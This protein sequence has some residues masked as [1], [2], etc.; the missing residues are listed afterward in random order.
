M[1]Y[2]K[3]LEVAFNIVSEAE[4]IKELILNEINEKKQKVIQEKVNVLPLKHNVVCFS[5]IYIRDDECK[6]TMCNFFTCCIYSLWKSLWKRIIVRKLNVNSVMIFY[7]YLVVVTQIFNN[8][9]K[10]C[11]FEM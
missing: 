6:D 10:K 9:K 3:N 4:N 5:L 1:E 2:D 8:K 7:V 11:A